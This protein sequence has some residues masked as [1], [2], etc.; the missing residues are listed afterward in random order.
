AAI[1]FYAEVFEAAGQLG[2]LEAFA[3]RF[4]AEFYGQ[5]LNSGRITLERDPW[6]VPD[7]FAW[8][9]QELVP[10]CAG[11]QVGWRLIRRASEV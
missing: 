5:P 7:Y 4:A 6:Q 2:R 10:L 9:G 8:D 3:S 11:G 1:E